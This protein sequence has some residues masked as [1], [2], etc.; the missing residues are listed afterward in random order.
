M[1]VPFVNLKAQYAALREPINAAIQDVIDETAFIGGNFVTKFENEFAREYGVERCVSVANGTDAI[2]LSLRALGIGHG[3]EVITTAISWIAT[4]EVISQAGATPVFVDVEPDGLTIDPAKIRSKI[5]ERTKAVIPV[6]LYGSPA[7]MDEISAICK[8]NNLF[9]IEDCAQAHFATYNGKMV[10]TFGDIATFSFYPGKNLGA[11]G[12]GG[13]IITNDNDLADRVRM[14]SQ[15][16]S[17]VKHQH[18]ME[19]VNS[20]LDGLQAAILSV[21]LPHI[22]SWNKKRLDAA[23]YYNNKL[24]GFLSQITLPKIS[25]QHKQIFHVYCIRF[26]NNKT[27][28]TAATK[29]NEAGIQT[30]IHYPTPLPLLRAYERFEHTAEEFPVA[31]EACSTMLSLPMFPELTKVQQDYVCKVLLG[32]LE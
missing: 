4:S 9:L 3:D 7:R 23:K 5:N 32:L 29:L 24:S 28:E 27:R 19:G 8:E 13:A 14:I 1:E 17:L 6:H 20:R 22:H 15:H 2:Y 31:A 18:M 12:D 10:G 26:L 21:K 16:G 11:Y 30:G 25:S